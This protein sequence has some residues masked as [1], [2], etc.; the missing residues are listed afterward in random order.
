MKC[1]TKLAWKRKVTID[2]KQWLPLNVSH[3][4]NRKLTLPGSKTY[5]LGLSMVIKFVFFQKFEYIPENAIHFHILTC[6][7]FLENHAS[8]NTIYRMKFYLVKLFL[9]VG[10]WNITIYFKITSVCTLSNKTLPY[11]KTILIFIH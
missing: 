2:I 4:C 7:F 10:I 1:S 8:Q 9:F 5:I 3:V 11:K 6:K